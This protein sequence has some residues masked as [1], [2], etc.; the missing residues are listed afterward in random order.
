MLLTF[1]VLAVVFAIYFVGTISF[2]FYAKVETPFADSDDLAR[3]IPELTPEEYAQIETKIQ[4]NPN[5]HMLRLSMLK[6][7][8]VDFPS[9]TEPDPRKQHARW[10]ID[11]KPEYM[12]LPYCST[13]FMTVPDHKKITQQLMED[14]LKK[15][16]R[17]PLVLRNVIDFC[18]SQNRE[19]ALQCAEELFSKENLNPSILNRIARLKEYSISDSYES[20]EN[21]AEAWKAF[22]RELSWTWSETDYWRL[23]AL[24]NRFG[25]RFW[26]YRLSYILLYIKGR[27]ENGLTDYCAYFTDLAH[28]GRVALKAN[29]Y[30]SAIKIGKQVARDLPAY[31]A[32]CKWPP[33]LFES[34]AFLTV[35]AIREKNLDQTKIYLKKRQKFPLESAWQSY[36]LIGV[37]NELILAGHIELAL[38]HITVLA[39]DM[40]EDDDVKKYIS[41]IKSGRTINR[42]TLNETK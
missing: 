21:Y 16:D 14:A 29:D 42:A 13:A 40:T 12:G 33:F 10:I 1:I 9:P 30:S 34:F 41:I 11:N 7:C 39:H 20:I 19:L 24:K 4:A 23:E 8:L 5:D 18:T 28:A 31:E 3:S 22:E 37:L 32:N 35:L 26:P 27:L 17:S 15:H 2:L 36:D 25:K 6:F 38:D